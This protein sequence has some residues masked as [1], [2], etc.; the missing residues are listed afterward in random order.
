MDPITIALGLG[1]F[2]PAIAK[3]ITG[4]DKAAEVAEQVIG[5]AE[6]VTGK[7][8]ADVIGSIKADP[9]LLIQFK[10]RVLERE[11]ELDRLAYGDMANARHMQE[12]ALQQEDK[13]AKRFVYYLAGFWSVFSCLYIVVITVVNIPETSIRFVDTILGFLLG[14][15]V[16][17][18]IQFFL[19]SSV[20]SK[21]KDT[22]AELLAIRK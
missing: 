22:L 13:L 11:T 2:V 17:T 14:T 15:V 8:G 1:Q 5:I 7:Y 20:G 10:E 3:W 4:S 18:I 21:S 12:V 16:A 9:A 19:G 6:T